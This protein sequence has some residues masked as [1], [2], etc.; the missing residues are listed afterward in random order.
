MLSNN[1]K[2]PKSQNLLLC[3]EQIQ[4]IQSV[5]NSGNIFDDLYHKWHS[6][7]LSYE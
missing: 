3:G 1:D 5:L 7:G 2:S 4:E 6:F